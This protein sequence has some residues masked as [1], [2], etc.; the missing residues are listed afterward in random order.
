MSNISSK[1]EP[2]CENYGTYDMIIE[3]C[4]FTAI[5]ITLNYVVKLMFDRIYQG[6]KILTS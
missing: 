2:V 5:I 6:I 4:I 1:M 3:I